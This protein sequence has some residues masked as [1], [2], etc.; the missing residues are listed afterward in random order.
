ME[1]RN[2]GDKS[3]NMAPKACI[4]EGSGSNCGPE[5]ARAFEMAGATAERVHI[6]QLTGS[7]GMDRRRLSEFQILGLPGGFLNGDAVRAGAVMGVQLRHQLGE[8]IR[9]FIDVGGL[10]LGICNGFQILVETGLLPDGT[11]VQAAPNRKVTLA[12]NQP[13]GEFECRWVKLVV[14]RSRAVTA[15]KNGGQVITL[16]VAHGEGRFVTDQDTLTQLHRDDQVVMQYCDNN[17]QPTMEYPANPNGSLG[18]IAGICN[19]AG[20]VIGGMPHPDRFV[21]AEDHPGWRRGEVA[22]VHG[23][24]FFQA[25][26]E[27]AITA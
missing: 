20:T 19:P 25:L 21:T 11:F 15:D 18:A 27:R 4:L 10:V 8:Q 9:A 3:M 5:M 17:G 6:N 13:R 22:G 26:V 24:P 7:D 14:P 16:P 2:Q 23:L 12:Q 1:T